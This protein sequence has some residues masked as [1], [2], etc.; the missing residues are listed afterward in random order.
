MARLS[1]PASARTE[2]GK[3]PNR[4]LRA[5]GM[6]PAVLY[7][8][9]A[10]SR[11]LALSPKHIAEIVRSPRGVNTI[12]SLEIA[13]ENDSEQ[14]M[15]HD[16]QLNPLDHSILHADFMRVDLDKESVWQVHVHLEGESA[17]VKRGGQLEFVT[18]ALAVTC[19]PGDIPEH[20]SL[21]IGNLDFGDTVR[22]AEIALPEGLVLASEPEVVV[23]HVSAPKVAEDETEEEGSGEEET[24]DGGAAEEAGAAAPGSTSD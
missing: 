8:G 17:G 15:I 10:G 20:L 14:V 11:S 2:S 23:V 12:F 9:D 18:R 21:D 3:G 19:L 16:Y 24:G 22:A 13:G 1:V 4:R 6:I 7:G 5:Q